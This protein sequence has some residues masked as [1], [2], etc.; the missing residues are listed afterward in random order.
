MPAVQVQAISLVCVPVLMLDGGP[1]A[2]VGDGSQCH[3][4]LLRVGARVGK[5]HYDEVCICQ[6]SMAQV[7]C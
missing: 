4:P 3:V 1:D 6:V 5:P 2:L 7:A